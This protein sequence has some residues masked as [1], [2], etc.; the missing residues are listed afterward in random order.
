MRVTV[1]FGLHDDEVN[2]WDDV[3]SL[4]E[5]VRATLHELNDDKGGVHR[6]VAMTVTAKVTKYW[7]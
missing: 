6:P 4:V 2:D 3:D 1:E 5:T 7:S